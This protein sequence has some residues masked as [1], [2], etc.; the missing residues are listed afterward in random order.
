MESF[1]TDTQRVVESRRAPLLLDRN[2]SIA[3]TGIFKFE[4]DLI[5]DSK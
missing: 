5:L 2:N 1:E 4:Y 3:I